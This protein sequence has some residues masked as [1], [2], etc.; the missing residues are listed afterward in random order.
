MKWRGRFYP[1]LYVVTKTLLLLADG[2]SRGEAALLSGLSYGRFQQYVEYLKERGFVTGDEE[3][4]LTP[5]GVEA[6]ARLAELV[7]VLTGEEPR[8]LKRR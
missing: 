3:L 4:R 7:K 8:S 1:D 2:H 6:A 5:R